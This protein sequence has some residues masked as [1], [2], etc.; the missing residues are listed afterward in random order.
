VGLDVVILAEAAAVD[1]RG[2]LT[3]VGVNQRVLV[4]ATIP[5]NIRQRIIGTLTDELP[6]SAGHEF[7]EIP[8]GMVS[9][10][11]IDPTGDTTFSA[12]EEVALP[13]S[14][15]VKKRWV[16]LPLTAN[17]IV[18][19][20]IK[21]DSY[22]VYVIEV[23]YKPVDA[24]EETRRFPLYIVPPDVAFNQELESGTAFKNSNTI[25]D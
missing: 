9:V 24:E 4:P 12:S 19:I 11:V 21:G 15:P 2:A 20:D 13:E 10:R 8:D 6:E 22:G 18:D 14:A 1:G 7:G 23:T 5:F 3:L 17:L 25:T 16:D